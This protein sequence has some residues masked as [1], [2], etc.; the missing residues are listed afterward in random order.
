MGRFRRGGVTDDEVRLIGL[1]VACPYTQDNPCDCPLA[2]IRRLPMRQRIEAVM[3]MDRDEQI[4]YLREH[5]SC[6]RHRED[7][8][9]T[10]TRTFY[11]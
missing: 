10:R 7:C 11:A 3:A 4:R 5:E 6:L 8:A 9:G 2:R 1:A